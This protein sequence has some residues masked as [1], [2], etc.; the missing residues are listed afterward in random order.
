MGKHDCKINDRQSNVCT[1]NFNIH[2]TYNEN[3]KLKDLSDLLNTIN[4][5]V[6]DYH[7]DNGVR[8]NELKKYAAVV[9]KVENGSIWLEIAIP[10]FKNLTADVLTEYVLPRLKKSSNSTKHVDTRDNCTM[11]VYV[12]DNCTVNVYAKDNCTINI[13][14]DYNNKD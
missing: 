8:N 11:N 7:R 5:S 1:E 10:V 12:G 3:I 9:N 13:H 4:L 14:M 2:I 6:N